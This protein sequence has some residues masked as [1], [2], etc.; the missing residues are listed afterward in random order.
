MSVTPWTL[1]QVAVPIN[2]LI[3]L[4]DLH[5]QDIGKR[6]D[7]LRNWPATMFTP[8]AATLQ[9]FERGRN[10]EIVNKEL[11]RL[12][13][14]A[15]K[16][17]GEVFTV[18]GYRT[19]RYGAGRRCATMDDATLLEMAKSNLE[20]LRKK[21]DESRL[22]PRRDEERAQLIYVS[23][24]EFCVV[25]KIIEPV[26]LELMMNRVNAAVAGVIHSGWLDRNV[27]KIR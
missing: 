16:D 22:M 10:P 20:V 14:A 8:F 26:D 5:M 17:T 3:E 21:V 15:M 25:A 13:N 7:Y 12:V 23:L 4:A 1:K 11:L 18:L 2:G 6:D 19:A 9:L 27:V 24:F